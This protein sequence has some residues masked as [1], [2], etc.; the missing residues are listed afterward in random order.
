MAEKIEKLKSLLASKYGKNIED[1]EDSSSI[2]DIIGSDKKLPIYI[3][4][5]FD[6]DLSSSE[7]ESANNISDLA[8]L[9]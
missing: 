4:E 9:L 3:K 7:M 1:I 5:Q 8:D 6:V 2:S